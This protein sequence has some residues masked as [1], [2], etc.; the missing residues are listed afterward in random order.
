MVAPLRTPFTRPAGSGG[1]RF[2]VGRVFAPRTTR[3]IGESLAVVAGADFTRL[4]YATAQR[5]A[6]Q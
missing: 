1:P 5:I 3:T 2:T 6:A 4:A